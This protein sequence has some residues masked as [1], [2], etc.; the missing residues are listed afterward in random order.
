[1]TLQTDR[2]IAVSLVH[3]DAQARIMCLPQT[4]QPFLELLYLLEAVVN[5]LS[6][7]TGRTLKYW[8]SNTRSPGRSTIVLPRSL[9]LPHVQYTH[10]LPLRTGQLREDHRRIVQDQ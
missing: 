2:S 8:T 3:L 1:M 6:H 7:L 10:G 4:G 5:R 9:E